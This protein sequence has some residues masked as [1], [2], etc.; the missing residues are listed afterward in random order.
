M[1]VTLPPELHKI[2]DER[3]RSGR[4]TSTEDV[5][6]EGLLLLEQRERDAEARLEALRSEIATGLDQA[7]RAESALLDVEAIRAEGQRILTERATAER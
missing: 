6:R 5:I 4:Y 7:E 2:V 3:V 1:T